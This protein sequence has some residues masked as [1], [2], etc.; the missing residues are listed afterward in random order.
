M[1]KCRHC[2]NSVK[3]KRYCSL[4]CVV[5][6]HITISESGCWEWNGQLYPKGYGKAC[7]GDANTKPKYLQAHRLS[8]KVFNGPLIDGLVVRHRCHNRKC[9]NPDHLIQGTQK[10]NIQ[11]SIDIGTCRLGTGRNRPGE[12]SIT[13]K[14]TEKDVKSIR[15]D[16]RTNVALGAEYGVKPETIS[17]IR[18]RKTWRHI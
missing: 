10:E 18:L 13:A 4:K 6:G 5:L 7:V 14:L 1:T 17:A 16:K 15:S 3:S 9:V 12:L 11:D 8:Y 2:G